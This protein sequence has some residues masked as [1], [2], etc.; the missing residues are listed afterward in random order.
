MRPKGVSG[1]PESKLPLK[2]MLKSNQMLLALFA[3]S[4]V[5]FFT[6]S[7]QKIWLKELIC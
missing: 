4:F 3:L 2:P 1:V 6:C 7:G 5:L